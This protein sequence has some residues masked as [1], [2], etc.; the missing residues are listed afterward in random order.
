M[1]WIPRLRPLITATHTAPHAPDGSIGVIGI[2]ALFLG[3]GRKSWL[4]IFLYSLW[5]THVWLCDNISWVAMAM[6]ITRIFF[7]S[8]VSIQR[9]ITTKLNKKRRRERSRPFLCCKWKVVDSAGTSIEIYSDRHLLSPKGR[10]LLCYCMI[11]QRI[12][13]RKPNRQRY[14]PMLFS[15]RSS[16]SA[17]NI[18]CTSK[19]WECCC[20]DLC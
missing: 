8:V 20:C 18:I 2:L 15:I 6:M 13:S 16:V 4:I 12:R 5:F 11:G 9:N 19:Q 7:S 1:T 10:A 17:G 14:W 3:R